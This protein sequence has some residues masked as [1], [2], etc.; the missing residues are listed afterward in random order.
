M[1]FPPSRTWGTLVAICLSWAGPGG[2]DLVIEDMPAE[3]IPVLNLPGVTNTI[4]A[5]AFSRDGTRLYA[6]GL[7]K[8]VHEWWLR[9]GSR[10]IRREG[11]ASAVHTRDLRWEIQRGNRGVIYAMA[12]SPTQNLLAVAGFGARDSNGDIALID[13]ESG[14]VVRSLAHHQRPVSSLDFSPDGTRLCSVSVAGDVQI[15]NTA[16]WSRD[17][18]H[19]IGPAKGPAP[20]AKGRF[21]GNGRIL[22]TAPLGNDSKTKVVT[23]FALA[24]D[25]MRAEGS[26]SIDETDPGNTVGGIAASRSG[27]RWAYFDWASKVYFR[28]GAREPAKITRPGRQ[29]LA[30]DFDAQG[31]LVLF[32]AEMPEFAKTWLELWDFE[33]SPTLLDEAPIG[34]R[35]IEDLKVCR[36]SPDGKLVCVYA[37]IDKGIVRF[38]LKDPAGNPL[39]KPFSQ[40]AD[41]EVTPPLAKPV[42]ALTLLEKPYRLRF[43]T[44]EQR[45]L[46]EASQIDLS[47][48]DGVTKV[49]WEP[50]PGQPAWS[51]Q[52][53]NQ[54]VSIK[55]GNKVH[56][57]IEL[58]NQGRYARGLLLFSEG[59]VRPS[60]VAIATQVTFGVYLYRL[61]ANNQATL[62]RYYR[63]HHALPR[64]L[65]VTPDGKFLASAS[66]DGMI[67]LWSLAGTDEEDQDP[68]FHPSIGWGASFAI[69][70]QRVVLRKLDPAGIAASRGLEDRD[71]VTAVVLAV[72][73]PARPGHEERQEIAEDPQRIFETLKRH[74]LVQTIGLRVQRYGQEFR[75][76]FVIV[77]AWEPLVT[78]YPGA[79]GQWAAWT[80][81]GYFTASLEGQEFFGWQSNLGRD[82][83]PRFY[84]ASHFRDPFERPDLLRA[85]I[86]TGSFPEA[87]RRAGVTRQAELEESVATTPVIRVLSPA[88]GSEVSKENGEARILVEFPR[89]EL[90]DQF[91][92]E[93]YLNTAA[94]GNGEPP[95]GEPAGERRREYQWRLPALEQQNHLF[96]VATKGDQRPSQPVYHAGVSFRGPEHPIG[97]RLFFVGLAVDDY[98]GKEND[99]DFA[100]KDVKDL[101]ES[102]EKG[103]LLD[104]GPETKQILPNGEVSPDAVE[105]THRWLEQCRVGP[106]DLLV[107]CL[108]GHGL[109][110]DNKYYFVT[111]TAN[112]DRLLSPDEGQAE[113]K[114]TCISWDALERLVELPCRKILLL[115]TCHAGAIQ[116]QTLSSLAERAMVNPFYDRHVA[117][118]TACASSEVAGE[119]REIENGFFTD[120]V[121]EGLRGAAQAN[122]DS[123]VDL[124]EL[125]QY[126]GTQVAQLSKDRQH[127][128]IWP[129]D[130]P[131]KL[132][133]PLAR[134]PRP[135]R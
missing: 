94:L 32:T 117:V 4:Y 109:V 45:E 81:S 70:D 120:A 19:S 98:P 102:L 114:A 78:L 119:K 21:L 25:G 57:T 106:S 91:R 31:Q 27:D 66:L 107:Y 63:D 79:L 47:K 73:D 17:E 72:P 121:I 86:E 24:E 42:D 34:G 5:I 104:L 122:T 105:A 76:P 75:D 61:G 38:T 29:I 74:P 22:V 67:K 134:V 113:A 18:R 99:L 116:E 126:A 64:A 135:A 50:P 37:G 96:V 43:Q 20:L 54:Q 127:P 95:V 48:L 40:P 87:L 108:C 71:V 62:I 103:G 39:K 77:P 92:F 88:E 56:Y 49:P 7:D 100:V 35:T 52:G 124:F 2:A 97:P 69:E 9:G 12:A 85:V 53:A 46:K 83:S 60:K 130:L 13:L 3:P 68:A 51:V 28:D 125:S 16:D 26:F 123:F 112:I 128:T 110:I 129:R 84:L 11:E 23:V 6:G 131:G 133:L 65:A 44:E 111:S 30:A 33:H 93:A 89:A 10:S 1:S 15:W 101:A 118:F 41:S 115:D 90:A 82:R 14:E 8:R 80:P 36:T 59:E 132:F 55:E 58:K